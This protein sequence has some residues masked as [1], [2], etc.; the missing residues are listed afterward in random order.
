MT[1]L[2]CLELY[3]IFLESKHMAT[4]TI[5]AYMSD[6]DLFYRHCQKELDVKDF[7]VSCISP[8]LIKQFLLYSVKAKRTNRTISRNLTAIK[9]FFLFLEQQE[10]LLD[11]PSRKIK[12]PKYSKKLPH[13]FTLEEISQL[14]NLP[15][16]ETVEGIR[17]KAIIELLYSSGLRVSEILSI[18]YRD[19]DF[20]QKTVRVLGKGSKKR[21]IPVT[22]NALWWIKKYYQYVEA[23]QGK[24]LFLTTKNEP[25]NR[26][27][28]YYLLKKYI[29]N[30]S[31]KSG[32]SPHTI[33]HSFASH[34]LGNGANLYAIKEMLGHSSLGTTEIYT[35][36]NPQEIRDAFLQGHPRTGKIKI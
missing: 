36:I 33:R 12:S 24:C 1:I 35:H 34:L 2:K 13:F 28:L 10:I 14:C 25:M 8:S 9:E 15:A 20:T 29:S 17:D 5:L 21:T 27:Q 16:T 18:H 6:L 22:D 3:Q 32:Y 4:N 11:N 30:I 7:N 19:L 31:L 23:Y 26:A